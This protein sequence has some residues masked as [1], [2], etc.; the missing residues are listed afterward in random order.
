MQTSSYTDEYIGD[1]NELLYLRARYYI[2]GTG[3]FLTR[4]TWDGNANNPLS[5]NKWNYVFSNPTNHVD[6]SGKWPCSYMPAD[7]ITYIEKN[8]GSYLSKSY[9]LDTY[10]AA[11]IAVQCWAEPI[12][13]NDDYDGYG[14]AQ[15]T[16]M[17]TRTPWGQEIENPDGGK[18]RGYGLL[19]Y[20][21]KRT[22]P[23]YRTGVSCTICEN[24]E[25]MKAHYGVGNYG[26]ET[27][28][29]QTQMRWAVEYMR[30]TMKLVLDVCVRDR[31][32][33]DTD[34]YI[35]AALAQNGPG[36]NVVNMQNVPR[37][38]EEDRTEGYKLDWKTFFGNDNSPLRRNTRIQLTRF[39]WAIEALMYKGWTVP[40]RDTNYIEQLMR[41]EYE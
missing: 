41:G 35:A 8:A 24:E 19:C 28:H 10:V 32:C 27:P 22:I 16:N 39:Q 29:D 20:I 36:F 18:P 38:V 33:L 30:R 31:K 15:V 6:P 5:L 12:P 7:N 40:A 4:D 25:Y 26:L 3:R 14:P 1:Y 37:L 13:N 21:I 2:P 34:K 9:W 23:T 17:Q 11:G